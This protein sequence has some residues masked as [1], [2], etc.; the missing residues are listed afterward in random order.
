M[1]VTLSSPHLELTFPNGNDGAI[2]KL[3]V[4]SA[5]DSIGGTISVN[6]AAYPNAS[7]AKIVVSVRFS[8]T[9]ATLVLIYNSWKAP[10]IG[11]NHDHH[12]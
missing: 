4:F 3:P 8:R 10:S 7:G 9:S 2:V 6:P 1:A 5:K 12:G 11:Q